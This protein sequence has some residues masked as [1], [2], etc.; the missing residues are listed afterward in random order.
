MQLTTPPA[1]GASYLPWIIAFVEGFSTLAVEVIAIRLAIPVVGSS[2]TLTGVMLG[3]VLFAL[4]A[5]YWRGGA[6]SAEW[7][8]NKTRAAL[9]RNLLLAA[10]LYGAVAFP[11]EARL[12]EKLLDMGVPLSWSIGLAA[13]LLFILPIYLASQT[14]PMLAELTN[15]DGKAGKAS[16]KVLFFST[17]GSVVGGIVTPV[18]LFPTFGVAHS[19]FVVCGLLAIAAGVMA[20]G[21]YRA[22]KEVAAGSVALLLVVAGTAL[23]GQEPDLFHFDSEYQSIRV[24]EEKDDGPAIRIM[25]VGGGRASGIFSE[26]GK[27]AFEYTQ[28]GAQMVADTKAR[29]VLVVGAAG[30]TLP[31]D[32]AALSTVEHVDAI[33]V[34][35]AV[36]G[37][38]EKY[39]LQSALSEKVRFVPLSGRYAMHK[40]RSE[41]RQYDF[42][43]IDAYFGRGLPEELSTAEFFADVKRLSSRTAANVI[44]DRKLT[45]DFARN[46]LATFSH[47]FGQTWVTD[48]K[49]G[50]T[51]ISNMMVTTW[52]IP[53]AVEWKGAGSV[54]FDDNN[55]VDKD[56][57]RLIWSN[58]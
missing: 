5:G 57:V 12:M 50:D 1:R 44:M 8:R 31:R 13:S 32:A 48:V 10:V 20:M 25:M 49:P 28:L 15:D 53:G 41:G 16:G 46:L 47:V 54:Y 43:F 30:F 58:E 19:T 27:T 37:I 29:N 14:V 11:F 7:D 9:S 34:D 35:P 2:I 55:T 45:S 6:L 4:S 42:A 39:F 38:A 3:V 17:V 22:V 24:V 40:L 26:S 36:K 51:D 33:D 18:W 23:A 21:H 52:P 56:H